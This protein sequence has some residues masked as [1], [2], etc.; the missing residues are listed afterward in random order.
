[1]HYYTFKEKNKKE[2]N[3]FIDKN[4]FFAFSNEQFEKGLQKL[5]KKHPKLNLSMENYQDH[6][7]SW[8]GGG[9]VL[10]SAQKEEKQMWKRMRKHE[11]K[12]LSNFKNIV[13]ALEY[14]MGN[15]ECNYTGR[16]T[17]ALKPLG[18]SRKD[19]EKNKRLRKAFCIAK[20]TQ[21][22]WYE[23]HGW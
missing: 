2:M 17:D 20:K 19:L 12:Y 7:Y 16:Y 9:F 14:E 13:D 15:H 23:K 18:F 1:M 21:Y 3:Q 5:S 10:K 22:K 4:V 11:R 6:L 8:V